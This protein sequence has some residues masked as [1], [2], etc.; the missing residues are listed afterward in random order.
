MDSE[1]NF[2][3]AFVDAYKE[4]GSLSNNLD[5]L[6]KEVV[7]IKDFISIHNGL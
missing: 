1:D 7:S 5:V 3:C 2:Q 6:S 4:L